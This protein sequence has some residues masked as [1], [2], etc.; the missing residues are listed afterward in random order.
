V[1]LQ[2][3]ELQQDLAEQ[4]SEA[5]LYEHSAACVCIPGLQEGPDTTPGL[6]LESLTA[7]VSE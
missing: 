6:C 4:D 1:L 3:G 7:T 2:A 5:L